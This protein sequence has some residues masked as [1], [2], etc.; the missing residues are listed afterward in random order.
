[1]I[2]SGIPEQQVVETTRKNIW[3]FYEIR[4]QKTLKKGDIIDTEVIWEL[5][6]LENI[7]VPFISAT[8]EEP[9]NI[10]KLN[11]SI[12]TTFGVRE[13]TCQ[14]SSSIGAEKPFDSFTRPLDKHG[15]ATW[16]INNPK[17]LYHYEMKWIKLERGQV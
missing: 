1:M 13:V 9:T 5:E 14:I 3:R 17:L 8:V 4:L 12:P 2:K 15:E 6:D 16:E 10:I 7:A 11:L